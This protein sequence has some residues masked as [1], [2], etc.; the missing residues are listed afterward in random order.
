MSG[1]GV[2]NTRE[3]VADLNTNENF[4]FSSPAMYDFQLIFCILT[5]T[6]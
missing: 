4:L 6:L 1:R 2:L 3:R 5:V